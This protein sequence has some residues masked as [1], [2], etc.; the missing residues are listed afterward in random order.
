MLALLLAAALGQLT[1]IAISDGGPLG[2]DDLGTTADGRFLI[3][4]AELGA[5]LLLSPDG[6]TSRLEPPGHARRSITSALLMK[7]RGGGGS[8]AVGD[9]LIAADRRQ[10]ELLVV[11]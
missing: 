1:P 4:E 11:G 10:R 8:S 7:G 5:V 3:P 6:G 9:L 2:L